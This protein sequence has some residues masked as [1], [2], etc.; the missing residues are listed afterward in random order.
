M[1]Y[2]VSITEGQATL[3]A[4]KLDEAYKV[5]CALND[6]DAV[7]R[8]GSWGGGEDHNS[9]RPTGLNHHPYRWF[10]W[11][12][13]NYPETCPDAYAILTALGF[14]MER[15]E[16]GSII[17]GGYDSKMGQEDLFLDALCPLFT[18]DSYLVWR[19]EDGDLWRNEFG[20]KV[21]VHKTAEIRWV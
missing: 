3:P 21:T 13:A 19:G 9:P 11:M 4:D 2:Y 7:K 18:E 1:G 6:N 14:E 5:M 15:T 16:D 12:D 20:G 8:G 17:I 10:S